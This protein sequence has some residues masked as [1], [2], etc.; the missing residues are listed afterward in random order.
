MV[1]SKQMTIIKSIRTGKKR[2]Q[3][4]FV[5][6]NKLGQI[7]DVINTSSGKR[8]SSVLNTLSNRVFNQEEI[9]KELK[10]YEENEILQ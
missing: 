9:V 10:K 6:L 1:W 3:L 2:D 8:V 7:F 5:K 4:Y